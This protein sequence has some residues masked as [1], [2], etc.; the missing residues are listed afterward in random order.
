MVP[1]RVTTAVFV[2]VRP[3]PTVAP[4][5][6][7]PVTF[8]FEV[9]AIV[10]VV[11]VAPV[12]AIAMPPKERVLP[13]PL[14]VRV[15]VLV[16]L[17]FVQAPPRVRVLLLPFR[18]IVCDKLPLMAPVPRFRS[19]VPPKAKLPPMLIALLPALVIAS[20]EVL[21]IVPELIVKFP[22]VAPSALAWLI[23]SVPALSVVPPL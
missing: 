21:S 2:I 8:T 5:V 20:P 11:A 3:E 9:P 1:L 13:T 17:V 12:A 18:V 6:M 22:A 15:L 19:F 4:F 16:V 23:F 7:A 14:T 10:R